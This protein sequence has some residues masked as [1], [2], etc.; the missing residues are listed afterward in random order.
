MRSKENSYG[1]GFIDGSATA[2]I[3]NEVK[4][5]LELINES[6]NLKSSLKYKDANE[7]SDFYSLAIFSLGNE[8]IIDGYPDGSFRAKKSITRAEAI[9]MLLR[10]KD[11]KVDNE[12]NNKLNKEASSQ[13]NNLDKDNKKE[14]RIALEGKSH[15]INQDGATYYE[16]EVKGIVK[17]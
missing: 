8:K 6:A 16:D 5:N 3:R 4:S 17:C 13:I 7:I 12:I 10:D 14:N 11:E 9:N 2:N 1:S 15:F